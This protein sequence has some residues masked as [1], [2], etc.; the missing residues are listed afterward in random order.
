MVTSISSCPST[1]IGALRMDRPFIPPPTVNDELLV[2]R[3]SDNLKFTKADDIW[4]LGLT[5]KGLRQ[6]SVSSVISS[7]YIRLI[8]HFPL[9][10]RHPEDG[11]QENLR[12]CLSSFQRSFLL[13]NSAVDACF[14]PRWTNM[15][16][17]PQPARTCS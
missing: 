15:Q 16:C 6:Y 3:T 2:G 4:V 11:R 17:S 1:S 8:L 13:V 9:E 12:E 10:G 14:T 7:F 5:L